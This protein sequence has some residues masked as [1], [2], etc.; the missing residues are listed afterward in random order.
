MDNFTPMCPFSQNC[1]L[2]SSID[3]KFRKNIGYVF[4]DCTFAQK[5][6]CNPLVIQS[7]SD[8]IEY[9]KLTV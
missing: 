2:L 8:E 5:Q 7:F 4:G 9:L 3:L 6:F 1:C